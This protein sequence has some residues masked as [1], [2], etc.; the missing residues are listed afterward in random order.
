MT[1]EPK[2]ETDQPSLFKM[3]K[4]AMDAEVDIVPAAIDDDAIARTSCRIP[5]AVL[6]EVAALAQANR[7][8]VSLLINLLLD[9]YLVGQGRPGYAVLAPEYP[10]FVLRKKTRTD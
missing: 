3:L 8:S 7:M 2:T 9:T 6:A 5:R 10:D 4:A 1:R